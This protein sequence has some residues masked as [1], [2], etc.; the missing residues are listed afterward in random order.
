M[1]YLLE[2]RIGNPDLFTGRKKELT[3]YLK[4]ISDIKEKKSQSPAVLARRKMGKTALL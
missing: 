3:H 2:E 4:W 1:K